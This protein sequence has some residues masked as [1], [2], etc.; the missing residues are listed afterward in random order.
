MAAP[1]D[2]P[3]RLCDKCFATI[4]VDAPYCPECGAALDSESRS[5]G[6]DV[7]IYPDL[8]RANLLRM[9][10][11]YKAAEDV[12]LGILRRFPNNAT[13]NG[14]LG[15]ICAER[16]DLEQA[17]EWY[18]LALDIVKDS[19]SVRSKLES[20]RTRLAEREAAHTAQ[21]IGLPMSSPRTGVYALAT[22]LLILTVGAASYFFGARTRPAPPVMDTRID[23]S[24]QEPEPAPA[25]V[26]E[27]APADVHPI[28]STPGP[29]V[30][31]TLLESLRGQLE[32]GSQ[33]LDAWQD[34]R[35]QVLTLTV[36]ATTDEPFRTLAAH[37]G[38]SALSRATVSTA[39]VRVIADG[40]LV[41]VGDATRERAIAIASPGFRE[42][43][44]NNPDLWIDR[45][46]TNEWSAP[47]NGAA[48]APE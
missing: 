43:S 30:D 13:A 25:I 39:T 47:L 9:R 6:S 31:S 21:Q 12:C 29:W 1:D 28:P 22:I 23:V 46:M 17:A 32:R 24:T 5:D 40:R 14:L 26:P 36:A 48:G 7:A 42:E 20:V 19:E 16:G 34:P 3:T 10:G 41:Y 4:A 11:D 35:T 27:K 18:E 38:L 15:D 37:I 45:L 33:L 8:A 2:S 44:A